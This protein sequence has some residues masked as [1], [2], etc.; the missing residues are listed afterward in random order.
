[1]DLNKLKEFWIL[2]EKKSFH[3]W[4]FS[5]INDRKSQEPLP[6]DYDSVVHRYLK[7]SSILLDMGT[8]GG[9][10]LLI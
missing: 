9:E 5:Y 10:Y 2:E 8:D 1:M 4:D 6:W 7:T 3:G